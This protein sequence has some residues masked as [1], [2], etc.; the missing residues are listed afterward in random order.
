[1]PNQSGSALDDFILV[2]LNYETATVALREYLSI[3]DDCLTGCL[4]SLSANEGAKEG[5]ILSTCNRTEIYAVG[6]GPD[7]VMRWIEGYFKLERDTLADIV[8]TL[9]GRDAVRH[10]Y[11]VASGLESMVLG[12][13]QILGQLKNAFRAADDLGM[14]RGVT[15]KVIDSTFSVAKQIR[16]N[17]GIGTGSVTLPTAALKVV[18]RIF[19]SLKDSRILF[20]G[21]GEMIRLCAE[22][23]DNEKK[24]SV[25]FANRTLERA[26]SLS[27]E[28][29]GDA[30]ELLEISE[31][32]HEYDVVVTCTGSASPILHDDMVLVASSRRRRRPLLIIDLAV[33]RDVA[34]EVSALDD[35]F[36]YTIDDLGKIVA[37]SQSSR[38]EA[39]ASSAKYLEQG[40]RSLQHQFRRVDRVKVIKALRERGESIG[41]LEVDRALNRVKNGEDPEAVITSLSRAIINKFLHEP[42]QFLNREIHQDDSHLIENLVDSFDLNIE[43]DQ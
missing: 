5:L 7:V 40:L 3:T 37:E 8:Y 4:K 20:V 27:S 30:F 9:E 26:R 12:E 14:V 35:I 22:Y 38:T 17:T 19:G 21:A 33:P 10:L 1:M 34:P 36:V 28:F 16:T 24:R 39:A 31:R 42:S 15:R 11:R 32:L 25:S 29:G 23:F 13:T 2:G 6:I 18:Q 41:R 43:E